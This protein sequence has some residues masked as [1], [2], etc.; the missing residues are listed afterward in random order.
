M[1]DV[2]R[3]ALRI[4]FHADKH[5]DLLPVLEMWGNALAERN[6]MYFTQYPLGEQD[7]AV[8]E[9]DR[10]GYENPRMDTFG[11]II[12]DF[13]TILSRRRA[14]CFDWAAAVAGYA[15]AMGH[16]V[17]VKVVGLIGPY[18]RIGDNF[19]ALVTGPSGDVDVCTLLRGY[20]ENLAPVLPE[21]TVGACCLQCAYDGTLAHYDSCASCSTGNCG[22]R[23]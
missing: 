19:H 5:E 17:A 14:T 18:G 6:R 11:Q 9:Q 1:S 21:G 10:I 22:S 3:Q 15:Q 23:Y 8:F 7:M 12:G 13:E 2:K 4:E 20:G 16:N